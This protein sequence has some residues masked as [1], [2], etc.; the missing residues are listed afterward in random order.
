MVPV[1]ELLDND[2]QSMFGWLK[3]PVMIRF[4][5]VELSL[6]MW[7]IIVVILAAELR[8]AI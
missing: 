2:D 7:L 1:V 6:F 8:G 4:C 5:E 3:S